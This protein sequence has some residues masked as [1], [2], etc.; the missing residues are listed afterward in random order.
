MVQDRVTS[1]V[2]NYR[3]RK[4]N[5]VKKYI[6]AHKNSLTK[7]VRGTELVN[8]FQL[9][10]SFCLH[11]FIEVLRTKSAA[12]QGTAQKLCSAQRSMHK[13]AQRKAS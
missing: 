13:S 5:P 11:D 7:H 3:A 1:T 4:G 6:D 9:M 2:Q 10:F 8:L 12:F